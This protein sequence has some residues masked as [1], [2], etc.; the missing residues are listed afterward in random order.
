VQLLCV[1]L[2][3]APYAV[4]SAPRVIPLYHGH[5]FDDI[6]E[7]CTAS[8]CPPV[9]IA[10][11]G[12][13][14]AS[15]YAQLRFSAVGMPRRE[16]LFMGTFNVSSLADVWIEHNDKTNLASRFGIDLEKGGCPQ[17]MFSPY[18]AWD[19]KQIYNPEIMSTGVS[20]QQWLAEQFMDDHVSSKRGDHEAME[21]NIHG[22]NTM[23]PS[24]DGHL[25]RELSSRD[26]DSSF[27][28]SSIMLQTPV[29]KGYSELGFK[30]IDIP[31]DVFEVVSDF[32]HR[33]KKQSS[34]E[35][36]YPGYTTI[37]HREV[38][39]TMVPLE[40]EPATKQKIAS[41][42]QP[43]VE[44]WAGRKLKLT[45]LYG[46]REYH[47]GSWLKLHVDHVST[48]VFSLI[49]NVAQENVNP[50]DDWPVEVITFDGRRMS[51]SMKPGQMLLY[52]SAKLIHGR[53]SLLDGDNYVNCFAHY[54]P[55]H[56]DEWDFYH[57]NDNVYSRAKGFLV[58]L[59][60]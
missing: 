1:L 29:L 33:H 30:L 34:T 11:Y 2:G 20:W 12:S 26:Q 8:S 24:Q 21:V 15:D 36:F 38:P 46:I 22:K 50:D 40:Q 47:R 59:K 19:K 14:C 13:S 27:R 23:V 18:N 57:E 53:P 58:D 17:I 5:H 42:L 9:L 60:L 35:G 51:V 4:D 54:A 43:I 6:V 49:V 3:A 16:Q 45:S 7:D 25:A 55:V 52:E 41:D 10:F 32:Y 48:H 56:D 44:E 31:K 28:W 39:T 37:N